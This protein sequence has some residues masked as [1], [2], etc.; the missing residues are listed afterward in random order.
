MRNIH[1]TVVAATFFRIRH[2]PVQVYYKNLEA[3]GGR[4]LRQPIS[5]RWDSQVDCLDSVLK[6]RKLVQTALI[7]LRDETFEFEGNELMF[8][9]NLPWWETVEHM[10]PGS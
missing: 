7:D 8:I 5:T 9:W 2:R 4:R 10:G 3:T 1:N 6:Y